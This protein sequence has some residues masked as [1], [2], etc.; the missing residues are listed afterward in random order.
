MFNIFFQFLNE[1]PD[2]SVIGNSFNSDEDEWCV[3]CG[4][5][6]YGDYEQQ[7]AMKFH[8]KEDATAINLQQVELHY[9]FDFIDSV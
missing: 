4:W 9:L 5:D 6:Q 8:A 1:Q 2:H 3:G 7:Q